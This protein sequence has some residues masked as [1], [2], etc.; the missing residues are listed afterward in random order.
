MAETISPALD[1][2]NRWDGDASAIALGE[3]LF[4]SESLSPVGV[5]CA[6]CHDPEKGFSDGRRVSEGI[7]QTSRH[8]PHLYEQAGQTWFFWDGR[9]D[10][11]WCQAASPIEASGEMASSRT[12]VGHALQDNSTYQEMYEDIFGP[13]PELSHWPQQA[14]PD[15]EEDSLAVIAWSSMTEEE[16]R[17]ATSV[18]VNV[19]KAIAAFENTIETP[20]SDIDQF[21]AQFRQN[22]EEALEGLTA[23][24][25]RGLRLFV[26]K[27]NCHFCHAGAAFTNGEFHN[28]GLGGRD[29][30]S[31]TD[32]GRYSGIE[33]LQANPFNRGGLWSDSPDDQ[34]AERI[35]RLMQ[36][37]EQ[38]G[39]FKVPSLRNVK[40]TAPYM[41]GGHFDT[42]EQVVQFYITLGETSVQ[43]HREE[44]LFQQSWS[45]EE[46]DALVAFLEML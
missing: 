45:Q 15:G 38:L 34:L 20:T 21:T 26:G 23:T 39:Q 22:E 37:T 30:L 13:L 16:Q 35:D 14:K 32:V 29:W 33:S 24:Q 9:C 19:V 6:T 10:S 12:A 40:N 28:I 11:L 27:G 2:S 31:D 42:L 25:E 5:S 46:I 17:D 7:E 3:E 18:F 41:H 1:S 36:S 8:A 44:L 4:F 43:G